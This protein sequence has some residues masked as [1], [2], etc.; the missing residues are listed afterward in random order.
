MTQSPG[1]FHPCRGAAQSIGRAADFF[2]PA[3][4]LRPTMGL[5]LVMAAFLIFGGLQKASAYTPDDPVVVQMVDKAIAFLE[6]GADMKYTMPESEPI[7]VA[8][9]HLKV[10]HDPDS[11]VVKKGIAAAKRIVA[12][13]Q[14]GKTHQRHSITYELAISILLFIE[15]GENQYTPELELLQ[16]DLFDSQFPNGAFGYRGES[17]GDVSQTQYALLATWTLDRSGFPLEYERVADALKWLLRVQNMSGG[18]PYKGSD[19]GPGRPLIRQSG[20]TESMALAGGSSILIAGDA[21]RLWGN[22]VEEE[23]TGIEGMPEAVR[24][25]KEDTNV[26]RRKTVKLSKQPIFSAIGLN[27]KYRKESPYKRAPG[28][29]YYYLMYTKER[30]YSFIE[31]ASGNSKDSS[32]DW[33]NKGVDELRAVQSPSGAFGE[34]DRNKV[35]AGSSTA[36]AILFLIR[37]TQR[38]IASLNTGAVRGGYGL[39]KDTTNIRVEGGS[40]KGRP[41]EAAVNDLLDILEEDGTDN[42]EG[43][44]L[45]E[46]LEL[47]TDPTARA[48]QMDRLERLLRG[49][50]SWQAR[51][52]AARLLGKSD[53]LRVVPALIF[54]LSDPDTSVKR[55]ARDGLRFISRKF[56]G[57][58]MPDKASQAQARR[59][60]QQWRDWYTTMRPGYVFLDDGF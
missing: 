21:L 15:L 34:T 47:E 42:L 22:T 51:R 46:D 43:K 45:P 6:S 10:M 60:Q 53:E 30:Y 17:I 16:K 57:F 29:W 39:P 38:S 56:D 54:A 14:S 5:Q 35:G 12:A 3:V 32:P 24:F 2:P 26:D 33:Y 28:D 58:G 36:F 31:I 37:S 25:Y 19:P 20:V 48:A 50:S 40:I 11:P 52:V 23:G 8:Y 41:V 27:E 1:Q 44:S 18:W 7:L 13:V 59:A 9:A 4:A 55:Y 49:S